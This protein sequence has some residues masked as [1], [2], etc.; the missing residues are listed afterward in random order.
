MN[1]LSICLPAANSA[2]SPPSPSQGRRPR[3]RAGHAAV[4]PDDA[5]QRFSEA[6]WRIVLVAT[7]LIHY[8]QG[9][10]MNGVG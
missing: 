10:W 1:E 6:E 8:P 4:R 5:V 3:P 9:M 7:A 2:V